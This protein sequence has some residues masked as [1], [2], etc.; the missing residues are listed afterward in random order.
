M[1]ASHYVSATG[2]SS[3]EIRDEPGFENLISPGAR[4]ISPGLS[5]QA[6]RGGGIC[7]REVKG[8]GLF[9]CLSVFAT[10]A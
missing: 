7:V 5:R 6:G 1:P 3:S 10:G 9:F 4:A 2:L 8:H